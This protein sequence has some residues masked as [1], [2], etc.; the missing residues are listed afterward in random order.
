MNSVGRITEDTL[1]S[2]ATMVGLN[3]EQFSAD[4]SSNK[5]DRILRRNIDLVGQL[6]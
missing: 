4:I 6:E 2:I 3:M 1:K 5:F